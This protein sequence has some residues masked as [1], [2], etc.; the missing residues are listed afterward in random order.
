MLEGGRKLEGWKEIVRCAHAHVLLQVFKMAD[1]KEQE[2]N[3]KARS[4]KSASKKT[5]SKS[6]CDETQEKAKPFRWNSEKVINLL[7][8]LQEYNFFS[9]LNVGAQMLNVGAKTSLVPVRLSE[10]MWEVG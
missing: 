8:C 6:V 3:N 2:A 7:K 4:S 10:A 5:K 9:M 1:Q